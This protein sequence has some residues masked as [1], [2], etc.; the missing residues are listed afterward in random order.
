MIAHCLAQDLQATL[1]VATEDR[2]VRVRGA[3]R[4]ARVLHV[5]RA[6][7]VRGE[8]PLA[9]DQVLLVLTLEHEADH[10]VA[11]HAIVEVGD[12]GA[13]LVGADLVVELGHLARTSTG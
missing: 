12:H 7:E 9:I 11:K 10:H 3:Q 8:L 4:A 2:V 1:E 6:E 5:G 13:Q